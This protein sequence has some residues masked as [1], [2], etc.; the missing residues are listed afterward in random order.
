MTDVIRQL[1]DDEI[2]SANALLVE[3]FSEV[4]PKRMRQVDHTSFE[5]KRDPWNAIV[6]LRSDS[7]E[8]LL[9]M[10]TLQSEVAQ[11]KYVVQVYGAKR[12]HLGRLKRVFHSLIQRLRSEVDE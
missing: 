3:T 7:R 2:R 8:L 5:A 12:S 9:A 10:R 1:S 4:Y 11:L 6:D